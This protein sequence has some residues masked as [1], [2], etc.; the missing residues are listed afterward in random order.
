MQRPSALAV[1][2]NGTLYVT[3]SGNSRIQVRIVSFHY[4][5]YYKLKL[6]T[7]CGIS[8]CDSL[9]LTDSADAADAAADDHASD[10]GGGDGSGG[11]SSS[12][13]TTS[14]SWL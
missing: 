7:S 8:L 6:C 3:D 11:G 14:S 13:T 12:S 5:S 4:H 10:G 9:C 2:K 1:G